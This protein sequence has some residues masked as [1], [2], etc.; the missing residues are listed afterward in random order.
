[1]GRDS[2]PLAQSLTFGDVSRYASR[3]ASRRREEHGGHALDERSSQG[4]KP[5][6]VASVL[7]VD[8]LLRHAAFVVRDTADMRP[9]IVAVET[10]AGRVAVDWHALRRTARRATDA[11]RPTLLRP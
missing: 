10:Y 4:E 2:R 9:G 8:D 3:R 5:E 7:V 11:G 1:M 6:K